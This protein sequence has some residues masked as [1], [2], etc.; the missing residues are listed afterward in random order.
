MLPELPDELVNQI[1]MAARPRYPFLEELLS[2]ANNLMTC[3][4]C[5]LCG[6]KYWGGIRGDNLELCDAGHQV[7][8]HCWLM[9]FKLGGYH[10]P[11]D[12]CGG[13]AAYAFEG[14]DMNGIEH[15]LLYQSVADN[16]QVVKETKEVYQRKSF[17]LTIKTQEQ[18]RK[19]HLLQ[20]TLEE[21][22]QKLYNINAENELPR[23]RA[24]LST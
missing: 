14:I 10:C 2:G 8:S 18:E 24:T 12:R 5:D 21:L 13:N 22:K 17:D 9:L 1:V 3:P 23:K 20:R 15:E 19:I 6:Y 4:E 16:L 7:C 11:V